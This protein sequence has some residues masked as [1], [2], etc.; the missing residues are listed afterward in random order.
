MPIEVTPKVFNKIY[1]DNIVRALNEAMA[2][3]STPRDI[4]DI[5]LGHVLKLL[6]EASREVPTRC[7][8]CKHWGAESYGYYDEDANEVKESHR[9]CGRI[10]LWAHPDFGCVL[11]EQKE[12]KE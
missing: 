6:S 12:P 3:I 8:D 7:A 1:G 9:I 2:A 11:F 5:D 4:E 10:R